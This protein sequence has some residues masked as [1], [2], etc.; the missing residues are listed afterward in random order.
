MTRRTAVSFW[1]SGVDWLVFSVAQPGLLWALLVFHSLGLILVSKPRSSENRSSPEQAV[2]PRRPRWAHLLRSHLAG[3]R[4]SSRVSEH[5]RTRAFSP[6]PD[7]DHF[8]G[9]ISLLTG[10]PWA[11][12]LQSSQPQMC[13]SPQP[14]PREGFWFQRGPGSQSD[15]V[16]CSVLLSRELNYLLGQED[17]GCRGVCLSSIAVW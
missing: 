13:S 1:F 9:R 16:I 17:F 4:K 14:Q 10:V 2:V 12:A 6:H 3:G 7:G 5:L 15:I 11:S 8:L